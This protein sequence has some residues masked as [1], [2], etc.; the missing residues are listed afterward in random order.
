MIIVSAFWVYI[1]PSFKDS[2]NEYPFIF[3]IY[4]LIINAVHSIFIYTIFVAPSA[5]FAKIS[6]E[7]IGGT[8]MTFLNTLSTLGKYFL[9]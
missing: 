1:T 9:F 4:C 6:D 7:K 3:Y 8:Y 2:N 5:F